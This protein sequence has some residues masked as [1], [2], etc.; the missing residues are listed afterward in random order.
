MTYYTA[1]IESGVISSN[2]RFCEAK[3]L[4]EAKRIAV[5]RQ[6]S[7]DT[8]LAVY[9]DR[10]LKVATHP[11]AAGWYS[12]PDESPLSSGPHIDTSTVTEA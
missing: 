3:S 6:T 10:G 7:Q 12:R 11:P 5:E 2:V 8:I 4:G 1:E 9:N